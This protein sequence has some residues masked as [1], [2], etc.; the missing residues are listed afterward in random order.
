MKS[1]CLYSVYQR[2]EMLKRLVERLTRN[3]L[4][5]GKLPNKHLSKGKVNN[6][7]HLPMIHYSG[8]VNCGSECLLLNPFI[9]LGQSLC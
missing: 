2:G 3:Q 6:Q 1:K 7:T 9:P 5:A 8:Q 4:A